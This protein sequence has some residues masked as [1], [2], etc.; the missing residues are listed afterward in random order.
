MTQPASRT[1]SSD[2]IES[3]RVAIVGVGGP[4]GLQA[5]EQG[6]EAGLVE[7]LVERELHEQ[8]GAGEARVRVAGRELDGAHDRLVLGG[9][10]E[11]IQ[12]R[13]VLEARHPAVARSRARGTP[14][15]G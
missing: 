15:G 11:R 6:V 9:G 2:A 10:E 14:G 7:A 4:A 13:L 1:R 12:H 8:F 5:G 3:T